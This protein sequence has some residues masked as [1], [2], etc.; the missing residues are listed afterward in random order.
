MLDMFYNR[1]SVVERDLNK[2]IAAPTFPIFDVNDLPQ[3]VINGQI[4]I[5]TDGSINW[6]L[7]DTWNTFVG[8]ASTVGDIPQDVVEGQIVIGL[9]NSLNWFVNDTW[10]G[11]AGTAASGNPPQDALE[12]QIVLGVAGLCWFINGQWYGLTI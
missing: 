12:G 1:L 5:C 10:Y 2:M 3:D 7:N 8:S 4:A 9:D 11:V 6:F